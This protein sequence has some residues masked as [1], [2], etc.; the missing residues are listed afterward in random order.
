MR[1]ND[2]CTAYEALP[3]GR[4]IL[5]RADCDGGW[6]AV[7]ASRSL[8]LTCSLAAPAALIAKRGERL[9]PFASRPPE[10]LRALDAPGARWGRITSWGAVS[11]DDHPTTL[12]AGFATPSRAK[13]L[14]GIDLDG[15][16]A[17]LEAL[18]FGVLM[19]GHTGGVCYANPAAADYLAVERQTLIAQPELRSRRRLLREDGSA[20]S[21]DELPSLQALRGGVALDGV[22]M[23]V[24]DHGV[25]TNWLHVGARQVHS[26]SVGAVAT[27]TDVTANQMALMELREREALVALSLRLAGC[28]TWQY[29]IATRSLSFM[30]GMSES[31]GWDFPTTAT[32]FLDFVHP[33][34][35]ERV[36]EAMRAHAAGGPSVEI[37]HRA[38]A[39]I[40]EDRWFRSVAEMRRGADGCPKSWFGFLAEITA[41]MRQ[42]ARLAG[43]A[44]AADAAN[45]AKSEFIANMSHEIRTPLNGV[46]GLTGALA[47]TSL[48][49]TQ[50]EMVRLVQASGA[51]LERLLNDVLDLSK[52]E[53]GQLSLEDS[54]FDIRQEIET[55]ANLVRARCD[56]KGIGLRIVFNENARG[57]VQGDP[58]RLRQVVNNLVS[59]AAKF[60]EAGHI[61]VRVTLD[62]AA[63]DGAWLTLEVEDT[64]I[65]FD[66]GAAET[67]FDRFSQADNSITRRFGG[68]GLGLAICRAIAQAMG[69]QISARSTPGVGSCFAVRLPTR[70]TLSLAD[71]D[72]FNAG[73]AEEPSTPPEPQAQFQ[74]LRVLL[75]E[76][77][78]VNRRVVQLVLEPLGIA[79]TMAENG[80]EA[81]EAYRCG[82]FDLILM[83]MQMPILDGLSAAIQIREME[84]AQKRRRTPMAML[85][86]NA[87]P[88]H[89]E[90]AARA[91]VDHFIPKPVTPQGLIAGVEHTLLVANEDRF[92]TGFAAE[93]G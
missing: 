35:V 44:G 3:A 1:F 63:A 17:A 9:M 10:R 56:Q 47:Q 66:P 39:T 61:E 72:R 80:A 21:N 93:A 79:L 37:D 83:D 60:T 69:G 57:L 46:I 5:A 48:N 70:R 67:L 42:E 55:T 23:G 32:D 85:T 49:E 14:H 26:A 38:P 11:V 2:L 45:R 59:N 50:T 64:G 82:Q 86:A 53:A 16:L 71:F 40:G 8:A 77:H 28:A 15:A 13:R 30:D 68:T 84:R 18:P 81:V 52:I 91:E 7:Y 92:E 43:L 54:A 73:T 87:M 89:R 34:D 51:A 20:L 29:D 65:G 74:R 58:L 27:F 22:V 36:R 76:D 31:L 88:S 41:R 78:P 90:H 75:A 24:E 19:R 62:E 4:I 25:V 6:E 33:E 12:W